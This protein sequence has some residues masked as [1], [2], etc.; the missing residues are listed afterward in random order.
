MTGLTSSVLSILRQMRCLTLLLQK[1]GRFS[2]APEIIYLPASIA[3]CQTVHNEMLFHKNISCKGK[4][5]YYCTYKNLKGCRF[6]RQLLN[7]IKN[8]KQK[9]YTI[10][11]IQ[12]I[13]FEGK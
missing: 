8:V 9:Q 12:N 3:A 1:N 6:S 10:K 4:K 2:Y 11:E 7:T 13:H 5:E